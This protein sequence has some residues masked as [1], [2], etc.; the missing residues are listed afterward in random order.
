MQDARNLQDLLQQIVP[1]KHSTRPKP[2]V[3]VAGSMALWWYQQKEETGPVWSIPD[4]VKVFVCLGVSKFDDFIENVSKTLKKLKIK[5]TKDEVNSTSE[6]RNRVLLSVTFVVDYIDFKI[7]FIQSPFR[8]VTETAE[9]F[10]VN[11]S[12]IMYNIHTSEFLTWGHV[13]Y[14]VTNCTATAEPYTSPCGGTIDAFG[15]KKITAMVSRIRKYGD[16]GFRFSNG[17]G[18]FFLPTVHS[19]AA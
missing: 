10:D 16:H 18:I 3:A 15:E 14:A 7:V 2:D 5:H 1:K 17:G 9:Q 12:R 6:V 8:N 19:C 13:M 4:K 11:V